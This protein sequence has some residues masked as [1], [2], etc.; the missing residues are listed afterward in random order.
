MTFA[1]ALRGPR[2]FYRGRTSMADA[3]R[4]WPQWQISRLFALAV[5]FN[6]YAPTELQW[7]MPVVEG[8]GAYAIA[9]SGRGLFPQPWSQGDT[10][11]TY[12]GVIGY[13]FMLPYTLKVN[14]SLTDG[15]YPFTINVTLSLGVTFIGQLT[16]PL[17]G[18]F[19]WLLNFADVWPGWTPISGTP[20]ITNLVFTPNGGVPWT[21]TPPPPAPHIA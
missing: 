1:R 16:S 8:A 7:R 11:L 3:G 19:D 17:M 10:S 21:A 5:R 15:L 18:D 12:S 2:V 6:Q 4:F 9:S 13:Y 14:F 20:S